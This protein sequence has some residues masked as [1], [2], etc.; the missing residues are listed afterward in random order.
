[1]PG[2]MIVF[3]IEYLSGGSKTFIDNLRFTGECEMYN[4]LQFMMSMLDFLAFAYTGYLYYMNP[5]LINLYDYF[6]F[7]F[8]IFSRIIVISSKYGLFTP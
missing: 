4:M 2:L 8:Q 6:D 5:L 3:M 7:Y 1:M